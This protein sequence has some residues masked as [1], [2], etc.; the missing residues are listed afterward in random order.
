MV[1]YLLDHVGVILKSI[2]GEVYLLD[3]TSEIVLSN[4]REY[5]L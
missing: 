4:N 2:N 1:L 3:A 5:Q